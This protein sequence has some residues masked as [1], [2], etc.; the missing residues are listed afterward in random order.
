MPTQSTV[1]VLDGG[2]A[3][4]G[5]LTQR[6]RRLGYRTLRAKSP[7]QAFALVEEHRQQ[8][9]AAL[10]PPDLA[11]ID[12]AA[13]L[14]A[15][16]AGA[17]DG[18]ISYIATGAGPG[19]EALAELRAAGVALA[20]WEPFDDARLRFQVNRALAR[21]WDR[22]QR[23]EPRAPIDVPAQF[24]HAGRQK[25]ARVYTLSAGGVFLETQR[26]AVRNAA[27]EVEVPIGPGALRIAGTVLYTNVPGNLYH[28]NLPVGMAVAFRG[29]AEPALAA[30]RREVAQVS[31]GLTL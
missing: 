19:A 17:P 5:A 4:R 16:A 30:I 12:L 8:V 11:V 25:N 10:I 9:A 18:M 15:L 29:V 26:P 28:A 22:P 27:V 7:E 2:G 1:L 23:G 3:P 21:F 31:L 14:A 20:L 6:L 13:A 24:C